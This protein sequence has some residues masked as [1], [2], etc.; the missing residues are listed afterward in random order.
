MASVKVD[1]AAR[2]LA[3]GADVLV[4]GSAIFC[5]GAI[6][7]RRSLLSA[8]LGSLHPSID[9]PSGGYF[10]LIDSLHPLEIKVLTAFGTNP[11]GLVLDTDQLAKA[12]NLEAS[13][14]SMAIQMVDRQIAA[15]CRQGNHHPSRLADTG[16]RALSWEG[17][18]D[19]GSVGGGEE[20]SR[21]RRPVDDPGPAISR[22]SRSIRCQQG[23][24]RLK[25]EEALLIVQE[26]A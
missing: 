26:V 3:A 20:C 18:P 17:S 7:R 12:T 16:R 23:R 2:I 4:A 19:R 1:N 6:M 24:R 11:S 15:R 22:R 14:L 9:R 10:S 25:K 21:N 5:G 13:Q 8:R